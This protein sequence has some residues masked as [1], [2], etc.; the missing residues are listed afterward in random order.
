MAEPKAKKARMDLGELTPHNVKQFKLI[1]KIIFPVSYSDKF[2]KDAVAAGEYA[3]LAYLDDLVVGAVCCRV[4]GTKI[5]IMTLGCLAPYRRLG[6]GRMMVEHVMNL[7]RKDKKVTAVFLHVDV[8]NED[9]VE[10][11]KT[12]GF[13]VTETVKGYYK[14][15]S[16]GDAHVLEKKVTHESEGD[17]SSNGDDDETK[18][19]AK[20]DKDKDAK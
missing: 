5:Y 13:E 7:A 14:K 2:Y 12:F 8:N 15:L 20:A 4:D 11:Y 16:P 6:L 10:F 18:A 17:S 3:R 1:N 9:A 19:A